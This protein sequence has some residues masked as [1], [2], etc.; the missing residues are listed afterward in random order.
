MRLIFIRHGQ[1]EPRALDGSDAH[2]A[3]TPEGRE[4]LENVYPALARFL[5]TKD[6]CAVWTSPKTRA[7]QTAEVLCRYMPDVSPVIQP[8]LKEGDFD[9]FC[10][11]LSQ[12][13]HGETLVVI[14]HE[15]YLSD[16]VREMT[17]LDVHFKKGQGEMLYLA[18]DAPRQAIRINK[19][20]FDQMRTLDLYSVPLGLGI[21][22]LIGE[23]H[24]HIIAARDTFLDDPDDSEA[25]SALR[26]ALRRQYA[27][28]EFIAPYCKRKPFRKAEKRYL[29]LYDDLEELRGINAIFKTIHNSRKLDLLPL[30]DA[31]IVEQNSAVM[32]LCDQLSRE[33]SED[34][35]NEALHQ[36][37][38]ALMTATEPAPLQD[39][40]R[41]Q[42]ASR[43]SEVQKAVL[44]TDFSDLQAIEELRSLCKTSR[45]LFEF[46]SPL[47]NY[48]L[49]K[50][51]LR[52]R[53]L[54][55]RL[56]VYCDTVYN[57]AQLEH[58]LGEESGSQ[59]RAL[60]IYR[61]MMA[62]SAASQMAVV[63]KLVAEMKAEAAGKGEKK[64]KKDKKEKKKKK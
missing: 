20:G 14:G 46:F 22:R 56:S 64:E 60:R 25:L 55:Q 17:G 33:E 61:Q 19:V 28:L 41:E 1:A 13:A 16:W 5:N 37:I 48:A 30:A 18:P 9:A 38:A 11:A 59:S 36:T 42:F 12:H 53:R 31:M 26:V 39:L 34:D 7:V 24:K 62:D 32:E 51:Y 54:N 3:L 6:D 8:F 4:K 47:A 2:R 40:A 58:I 50:Q 21:S 23:Q 44:S 52:I 29:S 15:P 43:Y 49:A 57:V 35:Y 10:R 45:Y 63:E 27:L